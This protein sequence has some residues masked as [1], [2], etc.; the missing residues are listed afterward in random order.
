M[1]DSFEQKV[2]LLIATLAADDVP[3]EARH[4]HEPTA[5]ASQLSMLEHGGAESEE[6]VQPAREAVAVHVQEEGETTWRSAG[7]SSADRGPP[8]EASILA[9][10]GAAERAQRS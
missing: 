5:K 2:Q 1:C 8:E 10:G 7:G 9:S 4:R 6:L 3:L